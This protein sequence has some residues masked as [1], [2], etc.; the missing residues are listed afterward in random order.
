MLSYVN[1][2]MGLNLLT[3]FNLW[4]LRVH[5]AVQHTISCY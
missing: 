4:V 5:S 1:H 2:V 3:I